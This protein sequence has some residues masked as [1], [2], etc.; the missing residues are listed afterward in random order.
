[1]ASAMAM[2]M[3]TGTVTLA[4][5]TRRRIAREQ[6]SISRSPPARAVGAFAC[7]IAQQSWIRYVAAGA[8]TQRRAF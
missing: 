1:L 4:S 6:A 2:A 5:M 7:Q 3:A 8:R